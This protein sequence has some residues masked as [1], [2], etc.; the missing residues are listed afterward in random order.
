M[1]IIDTVRADT[2]AAGDTIEF[3]DGD[4]SLGLLEVKD[5]V[6]EEPTTHFPDGHITVI[7][8]DDD[9]NYFSP[10]AMVNIY[11]YTED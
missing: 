9:E 11:G 8:E 3:W 2:L 10:D 5:T 6:E 7:S 4:D 1:E